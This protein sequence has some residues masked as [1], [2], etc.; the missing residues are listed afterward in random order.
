IPSIMSVPQRRPSGEPL[1]YIHSKDNWTIADVSSE[2]PNN[3]RLASG[4]IDDNLTTIW[5]TRYSS[6]PTNYPD[7]FVTIDMGE[8]ATVDGFI[9]S[10]KDGDRKIKELEILIS[11]D[12]SNWESLGQFSLN[13]INLL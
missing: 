12:N 4:I 13:D 5:I 8:E 3:G 9:F 1:R 6:N 10:Q 7:H 2:E 11:N